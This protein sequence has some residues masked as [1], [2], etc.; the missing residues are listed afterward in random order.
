V[1]LRWT[2]A[3]N[4]SNNTPITIHTRAGVAPVARSVNQQT[5]G[6]QW[7]SL[8]TF[9]FD[10]ATAAVILANAGT[11]GY[12]IADAVM[13]S[14]PTATADRDGDR[15]PD[16]WE[17]WHFLSETSAVPAGDP[18]CDGQDN[19]IEY[20]TG[21]DPNNP[22]SRFDA[23]VAIDAGSGCCLRWPSADGSSYRIEASA[24]CK[25][26]ST[27]VANLAATPPENQYTA[28][29]TASARFF[30]VAIEP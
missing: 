25:S 18:D 28:P 17:R 8:G 24:D 5:N 11:T 3:P 22:A 10:P 7:F 16:W 1:S 12:V 6:S 21:C 23:R 20:L 29:I 4:R 15:L 26:W 9:D 13:F 19:D 14:P 30:R 27:L 2:A